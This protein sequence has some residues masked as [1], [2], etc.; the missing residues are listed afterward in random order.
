MYTAYPFKENGSF[1]SNLPELQKIWEAGWRTARLCANETYYDCPYYEQLQYVGDT[2]IQ[3]LISLYVDG[4]DRL[5]RKAIRMFDYSRSYEGITT[6]RYP[7]RVP[8][9]I[10]PFSLYWINMVHDYWMYRD[11]PA[12]VKA[13]M[14]GVKSVLE[15]FAGKIDPKTDLLGPVPHWNFI[16]WPKQW[17]WNN[18]QPL[19]G[20]HKAAISGGS[21]ILSLQLAYTLKDAVELLEAFGEADLPPVMKQSIARC[22]TIPG[23]NAGTKENSCLRMIWKVRATANMLI[24][25]ESFRMPSRMRNSRRCS[26]N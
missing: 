10:P 3:A 4:D 25:W 20:T 6:S 24:S 7:S 12:F 19:G 11:D 2:R 15:W 23:I 26:I 14:P 13:C 18:N 22:A 9:Y 17:P 5:M 21:S 8:Q 16:D 1:S